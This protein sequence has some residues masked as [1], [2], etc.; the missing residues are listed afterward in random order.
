MKSLEVESVDF[1]ALQPS[2][3]RPLAQKEAHKKK[4]HGGLM[5]HQK[6]IKNKDPSQSSSYN[7]TQESQKEHPTVSDTPVYGIPHNSSNVADRVQLIGHSMSTSITRW[8]TFGKRTERKYANPGTQGHSAPK[9]GSQSSLSQPQSHANSPSRLTFSDTQPQTPG[10]STTQSFH[11]STPHLRGISSR[12]L[13]RDTILPSPNTFGTR[14]PMSTSEPKHG[15]SYFDCKEIPPPLPALDHPAF[16][17]Q[18][19]STIPPGTHVFSGLPIGSGY[20]LQQ[21]PGIGQLIQRATHSLPSLTGSR[22]STRN[23][24]KKELRPRSKSTVENVDVSFGKFSGK[25]LHSRSQSKSSIASSRRSSAEY[26]AKQASS[27][28]HE[29]AGDGGWEIQVSKAV[30]SL[31]LGEGGQG[32]EGRPHRGPPPSSFGRARGKNVGALDSCHIP[33][34]YVH[35]LPFIFFVLHFL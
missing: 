14:T 10:S 5:A 7:N 28:G 23:T 12:S 2:T 33:P 22:A 20:E 30:I 15:G 24:K 34:S 32:A 1:V 16:K 27:I 17:A 9:S 25:V 35:Y 21:G 6:H 31:A 3:K 11:I 4:D 18:K 13:A 29:S 26:S 19:E 8:S